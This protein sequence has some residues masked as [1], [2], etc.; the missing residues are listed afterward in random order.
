VKL[1]VL[2]PEWPPFKGLQQAAAARHV[3]FGA[4][5]MIAGLAGMVNETADRV[6]LKYLLPAASPTRRSGSTARA[7][8][9]RY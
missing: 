5:L 6:I 9:W 8:S 1:L 7:T 2:L 4:P 3:G